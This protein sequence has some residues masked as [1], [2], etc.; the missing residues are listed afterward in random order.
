V[1]ALPIQQKPAF[2]VAQHEAAIY[3]KI[4]APNVLEEAGPMP[5]MLDEDHGRKWEMDCSSGI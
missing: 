1:R 2:N 3:K 5:A 4:R